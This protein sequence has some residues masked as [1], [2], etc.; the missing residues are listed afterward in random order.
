MTIMVRN[1][2]LRQ[3]LGAEMRY[4]DMHNIPSV[5]ISQTT[6]SKNKKEKEEKEREKKNVCTQAGKRAKGRREGNAHW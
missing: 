6:L 2:H 3:E 4:S 1:D 5:T